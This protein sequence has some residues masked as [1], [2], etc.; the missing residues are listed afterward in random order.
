MIKVLILLLPILLFALSPFESEKPKRFNTSAYETKKS[1]I[2]RQALKNKKVTCRYVCDKKI[3]K[4]QQISDAVSFYK[5]DKNYK[6]IL[7]R[8]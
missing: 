5:G 8:D 3:Y 7:D 1:E 4:E 2:N 6:F